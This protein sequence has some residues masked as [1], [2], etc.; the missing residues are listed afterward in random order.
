MLI[1]T[2]AQA[3][4]VDTCTEAGH[5]AR[6]ATINNIKASAADSCRSAYE[7]GGAQAY[8]AC[9]ASVEAYAQQKGTEAFAEAYTRCMNSYYCHY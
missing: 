7:H 8:A 5:A 2:P 6:T 3:C 1:L 9:N 4:T